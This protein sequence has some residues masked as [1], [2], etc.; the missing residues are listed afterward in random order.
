VVDLEDRAVLGALGDGQVVGTIERW[1]LDLGAEGG[2]GE[3][4]GQLDDKVIALAGEHRVVRDA[5]DDMEIAPHAVAVGR[6]IRCGGFALTRDT[7][8]LPVMH[9]RWNLDR[10]GA[11]ARLTAPT[12]ALRAAVLDDR[13]PTS[14]VRA[15]GDHS[16]HAPQPGLLNLAMALAG[17]AGLRLGARLGTTSGACL[18][19][20]EACELDLALAACEDI[21][22]G[23]DDLR[24]E[25]E[26]TGDTAARSSMI[27]APA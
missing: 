5:H 17:G 7:H 2:L 27:R 26:A 11:L 20:I 15:G 23:E 13:A 18:A 21:F 14:T 8:G 24:L 9:A 12:R 22:E 25:V 1:D 6:D 3:A 19:D 16:E 10:E 4:D